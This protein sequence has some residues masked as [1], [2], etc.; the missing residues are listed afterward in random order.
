MTYS[1]Q[2]ISSY[3]RITIAMVFNRILD[4]RRNYN[5]FDARMTTF[6]ERGQY[7]FKSGQSF[8]F[9]LWEIQRLIGYYI[10]HGKTLYL[11]AHECEKYFPSINILVLCWET[12]NIGLTKEQVMIKDRE[13]WLRLADMDYEVSTMLSRSAALKTGNK[14]FGKVNK[15]I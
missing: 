4:R 14:L 12:F 5:Y 9:A 6:I 11:T 13:Y 1:K 8:T 15:S 7:G 3:R 2:L 10:T